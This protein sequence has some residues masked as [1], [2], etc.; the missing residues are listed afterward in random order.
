MDLNKIDL[1]KI[2]TLV[3]RFQKVFILLGLIILLAVLQ[4]G[5]FL[6]VGNFKSI[7]LAIAIYGVMVCGTIYTI[8]IGG[9]D[10]A[11]GATAAMSSA[12][13]VVIIVGSGFTNQS[14][15][16]G[17]AA[18]LLSGIG[19]GVFHGIVVSSFNVPPF[20]ITLASQNIVYG[21]A[22]LLTGNKVVNILHPASFAFI[23][24]GRLFGV[25]F[26]IYI[27]AACAL[28]SYFLLNHTKF[29]RDIYT[30]GGNKTAADLSGISSRKT[31]IVAYAISGFTAA[32][33]GIVLA[34]WNTQAIAK[35]AQ[36][37]ENDVLAAIVMGGASLMGG[38]GSI[39]G[40]LFGALLLGIINNGLRLMGVPS[41]YH[42]VVKGAVII[43]AV[44]LDC[45]GRY[46]NSGLV[47]GFTFRGGTAKTEAGR[48]Y[49]EN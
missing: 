18:G 10:L 17:L 47:R 7:F 27:L 20:L 12:V 33:A 38:E 32:L 6:T 34:S 43:L 25:A 9:I 1:N 24:G 29:G 13:T 37:Y 48:T 49:A 15:V 21:I 42:S 2:K 39:Q 41:I 44:A 36:G 30:V 22:Q 35:A 3:Q 45:Y 19:I 26:P 31:T 8:L 23:G 28:V 40:A 14:V 4:P 16:L 46:K 5:I 11:V